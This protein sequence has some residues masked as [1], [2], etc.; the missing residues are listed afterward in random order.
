[1]VL[2]TVIVALHLFIG[3]GQKVKGMKEHATVQRGLPAAGACN[4][5]YVR[6]EIYKEKTFLGA[7]ALAEML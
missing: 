2:H 5:P 4:L 6:S 3:A 1:M 7:R